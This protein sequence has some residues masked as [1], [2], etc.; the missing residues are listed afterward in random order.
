MPAGG[1]GRGDGASAAFVFAAVAGD[2]EVEG[3]EGPVEDLFV[4]AEG[5]GQV[6]REAGELG[7][8]GPGAGADCGGGEGAGVLEGDVPGAAASHREAAEEDAVGIDFIAG[9]DGGDG[10][11]DIDFAGPVVGDAV[12]AAVDVELDLAI[13]GG[14]GGGGGDFPGAVAAVEPDVEAGGFGGV[15]GG[16]EAK[17]VGL[18]GAV[19]GGEVAVEAAGFMGG[20][21]GLPGEELAAAFDA[22]GED[23][24][25]AGHVGGEEE[26]F[27]M[28][29]ERGAG[30]VED[31]D[32]GEE[33]GV[34]I[35]G[36]EWGEEG[37]DLL[38]GCGELL[39]LGG[40]ED[41]RGGR[42]RVLSGGEGEQEEEGEG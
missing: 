39:L 28:L 40:G 8:G 15:V 13:V 11:K 10:F 33:G 23:V 12:P 41:G 31:G 3:V 17:G 5:A 21:G 25:E 35:F 20:P 38:G 37:G 2:G 22:L 18:D 30:F 32:L 19:E 42:R 36:A 26:L 16:G 14:V 4:D 34:G 6:G 24:E 27:G 29:F 7:A 9:L 1:G